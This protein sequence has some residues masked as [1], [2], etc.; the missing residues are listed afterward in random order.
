[1]SKRVSGRAPNDL[2]VVTF[3]RD[4]TEMA[5]GSVLVEFGRTRGTLH[6]VGRGSGPAVV[7]G[8]PARLGDG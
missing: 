5:D 7:E 1:M 2:R 3:V 6:R 8:H 4:F